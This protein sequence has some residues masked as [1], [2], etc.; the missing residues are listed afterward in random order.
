MFFSRLVSPARL[1]VSA[2]FRPSVGLA[3]PQG[4]LR[5]TQNYAQQFVRGIK[6]RSSVKKMCPDCYVVRRKGKLFIRCKTNKK[7]KQRQG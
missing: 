6:V 4:W 5:N 2:L 7:H 1:T 3:G